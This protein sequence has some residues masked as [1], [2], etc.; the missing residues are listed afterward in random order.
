MIELPDFRTS[1]DNSIIVDII[2]GDA[3]FFLVNEAEL[4]ILIPKGL[5]T[6]KEVGLY[7]V[8]IVVHDERDTQITETYFI[9]IL[10]AESDC[11]P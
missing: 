4:T 9:E 6:Y 2:T 5:T 10:V 8:E 7:Q 3:N 11:G 1:S